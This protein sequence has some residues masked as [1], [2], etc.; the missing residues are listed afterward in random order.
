MTERN[1][2]ACKIWSAPVLEELTVDL[3]AIA[4]GKGNGGDG[5]SQGKSKS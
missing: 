2:V 4:A 1:D 5:G 3:T